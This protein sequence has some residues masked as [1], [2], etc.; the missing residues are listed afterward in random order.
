MHLHDSCTD[1]PFSVPY[2]HAVPAGLLGTNQFFSRFRL[3]T[4]ASCCFSMHK[5]G[6]IVDYVGVYGGILQARKFGIRFRK[7]YFDLV[8]IHDVKT[9]YFIQSSD[10]RHCFVTSNEDIFSALGLT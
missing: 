7:R 2:L 4:A 10:F 9:T 3:S 6:I 5:L 1:E 8:Q